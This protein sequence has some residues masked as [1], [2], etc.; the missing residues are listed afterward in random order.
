MEEIKAIHVTVNDDGTTSNGSIFTA[1][2]DENFCLDYV[3]YT[4][5]E[6]H[7]VVT[8]Y[9]E[10]KFSGTA[11]I[12]SSITYKGNTYEV[13]EVGR[14]A[15]EGCS[16]LTSITIPKS[17]K[18]IEREV[19]AGCSSLTSL[20]VSEGNPVYDSREGC[21]AIIETASNKL[22]A[23]CQSTIIPDG[24]TSIEYKAFDGCSSLTSITIPSSVTSIGKEAFDG[25]SSL[26]SINIPSS[27][28]SIGGALFMDCPAL[29]SMTVSEGN[30]VYDSREGCNA[31]IGTASN[32]LIAGCQNTIIPESV[33]SIGNSAFWGCSALTS[34]VIPESVTSIK[35]YSF[36]G[37]SALTSVVIGNSVTSIGENA[38]Y[39]CSALTTVTCR[40]ENVPRL[41]S[42]VFSDVPQSEA[43]LYVPA[44]ALE[45]YKAADQWKDFGTILPI[46]G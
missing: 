18:K 2:D 16:S 24:V 17:A 26:T 42:D 35:G 28:T 8:G 43:T 1:I 30:P 20:T 14:R 11:N 22:I 39:G 5:K 15:F 34:I 25:C 10:E 3:K 32:L 44:S 29:T 37:C 40:A 19:F 46:E 27:V 45:A 21:N 23:G 36:W 6:S 4:I 41:G 9:D 12:V 31:I 38:F 33:T 7:L 13:L